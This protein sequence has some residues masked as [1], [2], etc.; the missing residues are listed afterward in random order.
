VAFAFTETWKAEEIEPWIHAIPPGIHIQVDDYAGYGRQIVGPDGKKRPL[1]PV[2]RRLGCMMHVRRRFHAALKLG[3]KRAAVPMGLFKKIYKIE[4][5]ARGLSPEERLALRQEESIPLLEQLYQWIDAHAGRVGKT[6]K[7]AEA[8]RYAL[9]QKEYIW[10]CFSDGRFEIDNGA[11]ERAI[12][13]PA[14]GRRN[15]LFTGSADAAR[16]LAAAYTLVLSCRELGI[17]TREYLIDIIEK[18]EGGWPMRRLVEL[19]P[20]NWAAAR[21]LLVAAA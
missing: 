21:D 17:S 14:V 4:K 16:R 5:K 18:L 1:V 10:R 13:K 2:K 20:H 19:L 7:L 8:I 11:V 6:G 12:R 9:N 15:F 3:D